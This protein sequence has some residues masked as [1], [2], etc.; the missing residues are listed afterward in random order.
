MSVPTSD[1]NGV[2]EIR[3]PSGA[4]QSRTTWID[5]LQTLAEW[6]SEDGVTHSI[7]QWKD[8]RRYSFYEVWH[9]GRLSSLSNYRDGRYDGLS[10]CFHKSSILPRET[11]W[12]DGLKH[13]LRLEH[14]HTE[15]WHWFGVR[16]SKR[17]LKEVWLLIH[18]RLGNV[19]KAITNIVWNYLAL[20]SFMQVPEVHA[21]C[22]IL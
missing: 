3:Y 5:G 12:F 20:P 17:R 13:G 6:W 22:V 21:Y 16:V 18:H 4:L 10:K 9:Y 19:E 15:T 8:D 7:T 1:G 11:N 2:T 14:D